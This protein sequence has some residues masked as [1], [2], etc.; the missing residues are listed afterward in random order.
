MSKLSEIARQLFKNL[1]I[2]TFFFVYIDV[3]MIPNE[4]TVGGFLIKLSSLF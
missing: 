3:K 2:I 4:N 1:V